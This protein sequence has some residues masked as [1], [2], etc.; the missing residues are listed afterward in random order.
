MMNKSINFKGKIQFLNTDSARK[1]NFLKYESPLLSEGFQDNLS[2][3]MMASFDHLNLTIEEKK[4]LSRMHRKMLNYYRHLS[5]FSLN[6]DAKKL[7]RQINESKENHFKIEADQYGAYICLAALYSG[8]LSVDKRVEFILEQA[9]LAL[10][11]KSFIKAEP[12][13]THHKVTFRLSEDC[14]LSP[15]TTLYQNQRIKYSLKKAA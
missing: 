3:T 11:P 14:W 9:P 10:F 4:C 2:D 5:P 7:I 8:Q 12:K 15:F 13:L 6:L 1:S